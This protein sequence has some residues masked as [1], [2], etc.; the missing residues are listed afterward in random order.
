MNAVLDRIQ[1]VRIVPV[2]R[3]REASA[4][5][6]LIERLLDAGL[7]V[8]E[9]TTT[10]EGW[11]DVIRDV[12]KMSADAC[13]GAGTV[14]TPALAERAI[15]AG[16]EFCVS[17]CLSPDVR[18]TLQPTGIPLLEGGLT[19]TEVFAAARYGVAKL[20]PAHVGGIAYLR[21]LLAVEPAARIMPTGGVPLTEAGKWL[22]AG[23]FAVGIGSD[24]AAPGDIAARVQEALKP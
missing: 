13:A 6:A 17:P 2:I 22:A 18:A 24:L 15:A 7:D 23:A 4:A 1:R 14:T 21:S 10:I 16:A 3:V 5:L 9:V 8:I 12:R 20:F 11:D 19:P